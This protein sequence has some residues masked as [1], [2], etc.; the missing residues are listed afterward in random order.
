[1]NK[2]QNPFATGGAPEYE[3]VLWSKFLKQLEEQSAQVRKANESR[4]YMCKRFDPVQ[5]ECS[6]SV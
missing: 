1:M 6:V 4:Q 3:R 5:F 2:F